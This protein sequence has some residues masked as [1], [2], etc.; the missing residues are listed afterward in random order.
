MT[1]RER[2]LTTL[3]ISSRP[4]DDDQ[5][6]KQANI[7]PRQTVNQLCRQLEREGLLRRYPGD[8]GKI[9][10][11]LLRRDNEPPEPTTAVAAIEQPTVH[12]RPPGSSTE[13]RKAER[14]M[15]DLVGEEL[16]LKLEP[17]RIALVSGERVEVDGSDADRTVLVECWAHQGAPK[18]AQK[19]KVLT[20]AFK[21]HWISTTIYPRPRR[22]L[23]LSDPLAA[24]PFLPS[25]R[26]WAARALQDLDIEVRVVTLPE[27]LRQEILGAQRRQ[28]R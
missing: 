7:Q 21:L 5:L 24:A 23:C 22:I 8:D 1:N 10:N 20:D 27:D 16:G 12:E 13:Q 4:L 17:T 18:V 25:A 3:R 9:V 11:Q 15:L 28:Y 2:L 26:S 14:V 19:H 6:A